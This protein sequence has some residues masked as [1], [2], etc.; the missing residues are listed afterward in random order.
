MRKA[1]RSLNVLITCYQAAFLLVKTSWCSYHLIMTPPKTQ[2]HVDDK[3]E[4]RGDRPA[5]SAYHKFLP[6]HTFISIV[7]T[8]EI[9]VIKTTTK[10]KMLNVFIQNSRNQCVAMLKRIC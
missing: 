5:E 10:S 7:G 9:V 4:V 1:L 2:A 3:S 8:S 6:Q